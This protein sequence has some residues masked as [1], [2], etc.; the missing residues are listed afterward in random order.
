[1]RIFRIIFLVFIGFL[2]GCFQRE[3][4]ILRIGNAIEPET[5]DPQLAPGLSEAK[6]I[7]ALFEGLLIADGRTL[8][9]IPGMA[10]SYT[11][12]PDGLVYTFFLREGI[13]WSNGDPVV[14]QNFVDVIERGLCKS[15]AS[16]WVDF[17]FMLKN[18]HSYYNGEITSFSQVGA[19]ALSAQVLQ[20]TLERPVDFFPS[21]L[22]HW[23]WLPVNRQAIERS[24]NFFDRGNR[25]T[26][27]KDIVTNGPYLLKSSKIGDKIV[28]KKNK[29]YWDASNVSIDCVHFISNISPATEENMF[30]TEQLD[31]TENVPADKIQ[32]YRAQGK[33][34]MTVSLG[35]SF[36]WFNCKQKPFDDVKVRKALSLAVD[37]DAIGKLRNRGAGFE[38][39][40]LVPP[41]TMNYNSVEFFKYSVKRARKLLAESGYPNGEGFPEIT[42]LYN[43]SDN[44]KIVAEAVQEMWRKNLNIDVKLQSIEWGTF[45]AERRQHRF[46]ICRG[47]W[48]GDYNDA[49]TFLNLLLS[50]NNNNHAQ[51]AN[52]I[53]DQM[54]SRA[55]Q[56][57]DSRSQILADAEALMI[58]E[59][60]IIP[61]YFESMCHLVSS[62][63]KGWYPNI[64]DWH[65]LK[66]IHFK[67]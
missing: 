51:W 66:F 27:V 58:N 44:W 45:L 52:E 62:R 17:Y 38:A 8:Q 9:P 53:Y 43:V 65:P 16:P 5:L 26:Q 34:P 19:K 21:L 64:L 6:I 30:I 49:T 32:F 47:G 15:V 46:D 35:T 50:E 3:S 36:Y 31:I 23:A 59:M 2:S 7:T 25:W 33:L 4:H 41:G 18:A 55:S 67:E 12:S 39:Y 48:V 20:L 56:E 54:L 11:L 57:R 60:P 29:C 40:A 63:I 61:L 37:R 13:L 42:I 22:T 28:L 10:R 24:G 14:A 1:M